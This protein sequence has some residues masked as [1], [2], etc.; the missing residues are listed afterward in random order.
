[1]EFVALAGVVCL[2]LLLSLITVQIWKIRSKKDSAQRSS[3]SLSGVVHT[4]DKVTKRLNSLAGSIYDMQNQEA[5]LDYY[6]ATLQVQEQLLKV[7]RQL[8]ESEVSQ[9]SLDSANYLASDLDERVERLTDAFSQVKKS[10]K[11]DLGSLLGKAPA[12]VKKKACYFCSRP[13]SSG[14]KSITT[15]KSGGESRKVLACPVCLIA[16]EQGGTAKVLHF[17]QEG[18]QIHWSDYKDFLPNQD[19]WNIN[20]PKEESKKPRLT[21][22]ESYETVE[23]DKGEDS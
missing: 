14:T 11:F 23:Q 2:A 8:M 10:G 20:R 21:L 18:K 9:V 6:E 15:I 3:A 4:L 17:S 16:I 22:V 5:L 12:K 1:M 13:L 7:M 19:Y